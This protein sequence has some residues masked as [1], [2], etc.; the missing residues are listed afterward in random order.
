MTLFNGIFYHLPEP[1]AALRAAADLTGDVMIV[2][3]GSRIDLPDGLLAAFEESRTRAISGVYG[4]AW[5]PTGPQV[6][7][8]MLRYVGF[9]E[10]RSV[11]WEALERQAPGHARLEVVAA[12]SPAA[13]AAFDAAVAAAGPPLDTALRTRVPPGARVL[14]A[15]EGA[16]PQAEH[17][18]F[19][20]FTAGGVE[21]LEDARRAGATHLAIPASAA[22]WFAGQPELRRHVRSGYPL[23]AEQPGEFALHTLVA[24]RAASA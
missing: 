20:R 24:R 15:G 19:V 6:L 14:V 18:E 9:P 21:A 1:L 13:L 3:T 17:R 11:W 23:V 16:I 7:T 22:E 12:R 2:N 8:Q 5:F 10:T 4:L